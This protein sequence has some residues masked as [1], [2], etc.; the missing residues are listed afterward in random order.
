MH[1]AH[2]AHILVRTKGRLI[3]AADIGRYAAAS[4]S[5][6]VLLPLVILNDRKVS[7]ITLTSGQAAIRRGRAERLILRESHAP[8]DTAVSTKAWTVR[9]SSPAECPEAS[10]L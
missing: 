1:S 10:S 8:T 6:T 7:L 2:A 4:F 5:S 9:K 3:T